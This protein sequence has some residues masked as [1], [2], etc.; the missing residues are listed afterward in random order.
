MG[1][2]SPEFLID[3]SVLISYLRGNQSIRARVDALTNRY[4]SPTVIAELAYGAYRAPDSAAS[5]TCVEALV[6]NLAVVEID[7]GIGHDFAETKIALVTMNQLIPDNDIWIAVT[8]MA[9]GMTLVSRDAHFDRIVPYGLA[10]Q[11]W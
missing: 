1:T 7:Q 10:H 9:Y 6:A 5:L 8:A 3:S 11:L 4:T 2:P